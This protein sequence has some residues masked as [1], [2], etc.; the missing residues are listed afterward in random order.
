MAFQLERETAYASW[1]DDFLL[2]AEIWASERASQWI[3]C[4]DFP[5]RVEWNGYNFNNK[6]LAV[7]QSDNCNILPNRVF[8][9]FRTTAV[10]LSPL[11]YNYVAR[12][13][14]TRAIYIN[15]GFGNHKTFYDRLFFPPLLW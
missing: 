2:A 12:E 7:N 5:I 1:N 10:R 8:K 6:F 13:K 3:H 11:R 15:K 9:K 14:N 4:R